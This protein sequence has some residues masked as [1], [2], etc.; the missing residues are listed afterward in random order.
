DVDLDQAIDCGVVDLRQS[1]HRLPQLLLVSDDVFHHP[2]SR[3]LRVRDE[4]RLDQVLHLSDHQVLTEH[5]TNHPRP[6]GVVG[7]CAPLDRSELVE[8]LLTHFLH[9]L[10]HL[11]PSFLKDLMAPCQ[12]KRPAPDFSDASRCARD[13]EPS[14]GRSLFAGLKHVQP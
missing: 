14:Q 11:T 13:G 9:C 8:Q 12:K 3:I 2:A 1:C 5:P 7:R 4:D 10:C 6:I